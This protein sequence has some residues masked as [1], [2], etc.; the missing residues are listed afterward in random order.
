MS[1]SKMEGQNVPVLLWAPLHEVESEALTQLRNVA[2]L[3]SVRYVRAMPDVHTGFG[4][5]VGSVVALKDAVSPGIVGVDIGCGMRALRTSLREE[6][7]P[8]DL[9]ALRLRI[10]EFIPAGTGC[11]HASTDHVK[12]DNVYDELW[13]RVKQTRQ[14][15]CSLEKAQR[16]MGTLGSGNH[17]IEVC[18]DTDGFVWLMLHSGSRN[19]GKEVA[20]SYTHLAEAHPVNRDLPDKRV[21]VFPCESPDFADY[22][23]DMQTA[24]MYAELNRHLM[25]QLLG[26]SFESMHLET[27]HVGPSISCHH[28]YA[29]E[30]EI[31]GEKLIVARKGAIEAREGQWGII[32]GA[33]GRKSFIVQGLGN[34]ESLMSASHGAGR[35]MSRSKANKTF[36][37]EDL[38][39]ST[40]GV[41]CFI[42]KGVLD[43]IAMAY[44]DIAV[45]MQ[46]Q[47]DLVVPKYEL[48][49]LITVKGH[50]EH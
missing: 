48:H 17:F 6:M 3:P 31:N 32:P 34:E 5:P 47:V 21:A 14:A 35:R 9:K 12:G 36:T 43:E 8:K 50:N 39:E 24:Q 20:E 29:I 27:G 2:N 25:M 19:F 10:E 37:V 40:K 46:N 33:M 41:E 22:W 26:L 28:N 23:R 18:A 38:K 30:E 45:V 13:E 15:K 1:I 11:A 49:A 16:Q 4:V 42:G 44:K 7:L